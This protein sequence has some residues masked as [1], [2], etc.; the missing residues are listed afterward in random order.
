MGA[1]TGIKKHTVQAFQ[2]QRRA[3]SNNDRTQA[4]GALN[5]FCL[6]WMNAHLAIRNACTTVVGD[7]G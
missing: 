3:S 6:S 7:S 4:D 1:L 5:V 2:S